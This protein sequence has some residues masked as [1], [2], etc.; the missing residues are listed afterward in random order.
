MITFSNNFMI[1]LYT[2]SLFVLQNTNYQNYQKVI[3][4]A[5]VFLSTV[6]VQVFYV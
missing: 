3:L 1:A 5:Q 6:K 2:I 4:K